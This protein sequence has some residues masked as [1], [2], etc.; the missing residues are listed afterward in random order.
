MYAMHSY[1]KVSVVSIEEFQN[2]LNRFKYIKKLFTRYHDNGDLKERLILNHLI[3]LYN[4]FGNSTTSML[5]Y[6]IPSN[7]WNIL[8]TFLIFLNRSPEYI[9]DFNLYTVE[10]EIDQTVADK[11]REL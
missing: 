1:D 6:K 10:L 4:M 2:D 5:F 7:H 9:E 3:I 11:L 8:N